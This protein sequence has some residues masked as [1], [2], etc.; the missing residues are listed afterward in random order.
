MKFVSMSTE[1]GGVSL[2]CEKKRLLAC[3]CRFLVTGFG[4]AAFLTRLSLALI[5]RLSLA[6]LTF[7]GLLLRKK[8][9]ERYYN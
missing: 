5:I 7:I 6:T 3:C 2:L 9:S 8:T 1:N 4:C